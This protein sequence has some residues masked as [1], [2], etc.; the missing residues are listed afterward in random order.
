MVSHLQAGGAPSNKVV[1]WADE[2][3]PAEGFTI[4]AS[5]QQVEKPSDSQVHNTPR[6]SLLLETVQYCPT[7]TL[8]N[9]FR[10]GVGRLTMCQ[11]LHSHR[12]P[13]TAWHYAC[14]PLRIWS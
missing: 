14:L 3:A 13:D 4:G 6:I 5:M 12:E 1:R 9:N 11:R 2:V 10:L 7:H 8:L